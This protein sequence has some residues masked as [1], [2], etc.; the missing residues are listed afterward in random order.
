MKF[1]FL[2]LF[3]TIWLQLSVSTKKKYSF[4]FSISDSLQYLSWPLFIGS[5]VFE[6]EIE[7]AAKPAVNIILE[8]V[9]CWKN[10]VNS[11]LALKYLRGDEE[12][13]SGVIHKPRGQK[14]ALF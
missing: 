9:F 12:T 4:H 6:V 14:F 2:S 5:A 10:T 8:K 1:D 13:H 11:I 7:I 3:V